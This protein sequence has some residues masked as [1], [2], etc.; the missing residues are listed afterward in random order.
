M[1]RRQ[2]ISEQNTVYHVML[3]GNDGQ[4]IF[5]DDQDRC[6][7]CF[8]LQE[9]IERFLYNVYGFC[10]MKNH[11]HLVIKIGPTPLSSII[12]NLAFRYARYIN[13]RYDRVG[14]LFQGRFKSILVQEN[15]YLK[16]LVRYVHLNPV[17]ANITKLP[18]HY[19]WSGH[20]ALIGLESITWISKD[21][22]LRLFDQ[23]Y[24]NAVNKF[25]KYIYDGIGLEIDPAIRYGSHNGILLGDDEFAKLYMETDVNKE[26]ND[27]IRLEDLVEFVSSHLEISLND[28][29]SSSKNRDIS[30]AR[31]VLSFIV[32]KY[33]HLNLTALADL[34]QRDVS[35]LSR[36]AK[37]FSI[38]LKQNRELQKNL[39]EIERKIEMS[40]C[41]A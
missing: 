33:P 6:R 12:Q 39:E 24:Q 23:N 7:F 38:Q 1:A 5:F 34:L 8:L 28:L 40:K 36:L 11:V 31:G 20:R 25:S 27:S 14:H 41:Q 16:E 32:K 3:R 18:E 29:M 19:L 13:K 4:Q 22:I 26:F 10:F 37:K 15:R 17:R 21:Y 9:G 2:R 35:G 30:Y